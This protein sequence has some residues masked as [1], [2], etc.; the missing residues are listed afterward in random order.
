MKKNNSVRT[1][2]ERRSN[3]NTVLTMISEK[4]HPHESLKYMI[5]PF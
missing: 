5:P 1:E 4:Y 3:Y 2:L